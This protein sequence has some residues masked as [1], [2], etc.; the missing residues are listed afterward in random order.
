MIPL[1]IRDVHKLF[2]MHT[3]ALKYPLVFQ[4]PCAISES[5]PE[6]NCVDESR[7]LTRM[8]ANR[9]KVQDRVQITLD[10]PCNEELLQ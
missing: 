5:C 3:V 1:K 4:A 2:V 8:D 10:F 6:I 9:D 7:F